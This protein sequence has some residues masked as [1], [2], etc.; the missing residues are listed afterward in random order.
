MGCRASGC[1]GSTCLGAR[2]PTVSP[3]PNNQPCQ[4]PINY[5]VIMQNTSPR[6]TLGPR[7]QVQAGRGP[8]SGSTAQALSATT[9]AKDAFT[10][11]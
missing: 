7:Q 5:C 9:R 3:M 4:R 2:Q 8:A 10:V 1:L 11:C 6:L